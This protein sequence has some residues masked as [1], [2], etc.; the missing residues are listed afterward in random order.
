M[1]L[2]SWLCELEKQKTD[3]YYIALE[4]QN[5]E[6]SGAMIPFEQDW[7]RFR[8]AK[9]TPKKIGQFVAFWEKKAG[10]NSPYFSDT[11]A[12][13]T[14]IYVESK[15]QSGVF[16]FPKKVLVEQGIL[17]SSAKKGKMAIRVYP[18]WDAPTSKQAQ[19]TQKWQVQYFYQLNQQQNETLQKLNYMIIK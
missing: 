6:Y 13:F 2:N 5:K 18:S 1:E 19:Q 11:K 10:K 7:I 17:S 14:V 4:E 9:I 3:E 12:S 8:K 16:I 15:E